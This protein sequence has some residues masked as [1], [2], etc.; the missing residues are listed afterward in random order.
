MS[1]RNGQFDEILQ[2]FGP[3]AG[4]KKIGWGGCRFNG[5][6]GMKGGI[7]I[8]IKNKHRERVRVVNGRG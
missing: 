6:S 2:R 8:V 5:P 3:L 1:E 7:G 4:Y